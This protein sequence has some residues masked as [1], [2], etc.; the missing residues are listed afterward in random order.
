MDDRRST[1]GTSEVSKLAA[2]WLSE[3]GDV[4]YR[5]A[6]RRCG[7][8]EVA[9]DLVQDTLLAAM[10]SWDSF[11]GASSE[12]TWLVGI[13]RH[14]L[15]DHLRRRARDPAW[16][17]EV[18]GEVGQPNAEFRNGYWIQRPAEW[19]DIS[20]PEA[21]ELR[22]IMHNSL[23]QMPEAMRLAFTLREIDEIPSKMVCEVLG[24]TP[25]NLWTLVHR[26]K[27]RLRKDLSRN[28]F[29]RPEAEGA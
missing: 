29:E 10:G 4:L 15:L 17:D 26:A 3:H 12:R 23:A 22:T 13:L 14:R 27:L 16:L 2:G 25:T 24:I 5:Y 9:E 19:P 1:P 20:S 8:P 6:L 7:R 21:D 11:R 18:R 28:W